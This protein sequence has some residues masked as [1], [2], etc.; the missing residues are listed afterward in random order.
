MKVLVRLPFLFVL[1][2]LLAPTPAHAFTV[3]IDPG[4]GG[5][6]DGA[7][8][9]TGAK[10]KAVSLAVAKELQ[11]A[12]EKEPGI[13]TILTRDSDVHVELQDRTHMANQ[14]HADLFIANVAHER[15]FRPISEWLTQQSTSSLRVRE[16]P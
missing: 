7:R 14:A 16:V 15:V 11:K 9:P 13:K 8:S 3:A 12:L 10:E 1:M 4:H 2:A 6:K 5:A